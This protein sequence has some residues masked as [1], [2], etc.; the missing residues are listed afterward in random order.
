MIRATFPGVVLGMVLG[1]A[2]SDVLL[3]DIVVLFLCGRDAP[4][5]VV[6][7]GDA[8]ISELTLT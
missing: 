4:D 7:V 6:K 5:E 2:G 3:L 8:P 1:L